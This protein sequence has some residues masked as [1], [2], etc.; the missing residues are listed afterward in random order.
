LVEAKTPPDAKPEPA[1]GDEELPSFRKASP[2][3]AIDLARVRFLQGERIE[4]RTLA[5]DLGIGRTTLYR[6]VGE[7]EEL[8]EEVFAG[9]VDEW[10][11]VVE[12]Q[13]SGTGEER[14]L[15]IFTR[16]L[17]IAS[18]SSPLSDFA[19]REPALTMRLL[20]DRRGKVA[21]RSKVLISGLVEEHLPDRDVP[22]NI[23]DAIEMSTAALVWANIAA[24][25]E[26]DIEG[27]ISLTETLLDVC[28]R[29]QA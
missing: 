17:D 22:D 13:A 26:P 2:E 15:D 3:D 28:P 4:M 18:A 10:F 27:A 24:E 7:R 11:R 5:Q 19:S 14:L 9:L 16:F 23:V 21:T 8:I 25:R 12:G 29:K 6:W 20:L 1:R